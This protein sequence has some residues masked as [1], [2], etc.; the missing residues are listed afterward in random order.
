MARKKA[1]P[2]QTQAGV[3]DVSAAPGMFVLKKNH[4]LTINGR[5]NTFY[6]AGTTFDPATD[7]E[8]ISRLARA[9]A[10]IEQ[11]SAEPVTAEESTEQDDGAQEGDG[12]AESGEQNEDKE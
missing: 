5:A 9:G 6:A 8:V 3:V 10:Q 11:T 12:S 1:A 2:V 7:G 4:G